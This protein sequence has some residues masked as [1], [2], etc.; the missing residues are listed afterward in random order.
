VKRRLKLLGKL[1]YVATMRESGRVGVLKQNRK[2]IK[3]MNEQV[4]KN[5]RKCDLLL[6][7]ARQDEE[8]TEALITH[9]RFLM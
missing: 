6:D 3:E 7:N 9:F 5:G 2:N 8:T 4:M 1:K